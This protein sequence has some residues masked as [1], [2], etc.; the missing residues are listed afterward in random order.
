MPTEYADQDEMILDSVGRFLDR[1]VKP[2]VRALEHDDI[3]PED[4]VEGMKALGLF[5][6][7]IGTEYGGLGLSATTYA[8]IVE[9]VSA[10]WMSLSGIFNSHLIMAAAVE[11]FGTASQKQEFLPRFASGE[12]RGG[13]ALTEPD[14]GTDLQAIRTVARRPINQKGGNQDYIV[15]G[16]KTWISNGIYGQIFALLVK[17]DPAAEPRHRGMSLFLAEKGPGFT[18]SRKLEKLGYKGIDSAELVFDDYRIPAD[19]LIGGEEG[20]GLQHALGG[21]ELGRINVAARGVGVARAALDEA[22]RYSQVR[23]T[24]GK[25][26]CEH[27]AIQ[28]KLADMAT[29]VEASRLLVEKAAH[30]YDKGERCDMEAGM[31]KLFASDA[32]VNVSLEA[33]RI[34]GGYGY[35]KEF[36]VERLYR[37]APLLVI[38]EGTNELQRIIIA[39]QLIARNKV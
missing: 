16:T 5:G 18:V 12:L 37:D 4:I 17:T 6:A 35:S 26:I 9:T 29:Q 27:Q 22:V 10:V 36:T 24:F 32:A 23:K 2:H 13:L 31:A 11:R 28:L 30:A 15:N 1:E 33:M 8:K 7:T 3:Y 38:G 19:R 34:H 39:R 25:P 20:R 21:L 14:C